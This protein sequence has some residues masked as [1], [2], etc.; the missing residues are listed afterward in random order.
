[1]DTITHTLFGIG[2]YKAVNKE[3]MSK[4]EKQA[5]LFTSIGASQIPDI[6]V[7]SQLWDT[8]GQ[9]QMWHRGITHS[10][11]LV[12]V[13][14]V[15]FSLLNSLFFRLKNWHFFWI[16]FLAVFIHIT[17]DVFN[18]WGT[19]YLEPFSNV[20]LTFGTVSIIDFVIWFLFLIAFIISKTAKRIKEYRLFRF[21]W[22]LIALHVLVQ[23][24]QGYI[25]YEQHKPHYEQVALSASFVPWNFSIIGKNGDT[26]DI[27][28]DSLLTK[29]RL[30]YQLQSA[31]DNDL[32]EL[33]KQNP[34][35]RTLNEWSP[36]VVVVNNDQQFG[37][38]DPRFYRKGQS[39]L[40]EYIEKTQK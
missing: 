16:A 15:L 13:W 39:F 31:S 37:I 33:F 34:K 4:K 28:Q 29:G 6:D 27:I 8:T 9:Y 7:I 1:M 30:I 40:F 19:G 17:S 10:I 24:V 32:E 25:L 11:F 36:F 35:A 22:A 26:V 5:L 23:S 12:P 2:I 21:T 14:A 20:R 38:Y 3:N 18:A